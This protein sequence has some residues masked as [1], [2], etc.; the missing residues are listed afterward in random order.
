[1]LNSNTYMAGVQAVLMADWAAMVADIPSIY[2][3]CK[4]GSPSLLVRYFGR[5]KFRLLTRH[6]IAEYVLLQ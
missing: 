2:G 1:M 6:F 4:G 3:Y 5:I